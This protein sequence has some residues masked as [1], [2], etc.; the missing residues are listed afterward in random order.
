METT[1]G[2]Q[3]KYGEYWMKDSD[4]ISYEKCLDKE[5]YL[6]GEVHTLLGICGSFDGAHIAS[7]K[8]DLYVLK[9]T[10]YKFKVVYKKR[11]IESGEY[12]KAGEISTRA[13]K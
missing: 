11:G 13:C 9:G 4:S 7:G 5:I 2:K 3:G 1:Y 12:G 6:Q 10:K 8:I